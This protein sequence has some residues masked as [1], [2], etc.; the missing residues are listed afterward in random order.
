MVAFSGKRSKP[1]FYYNFKTEQSRETYVQE[2]LQGKLEMSEWKQQQ[3]D[4]RILTE[5]PVK[6][7]DIFYT[8]WGYDQ[9]NVEFYQI[10]DVKGQFAT[11]KQICAQT[12][13]GSQGRDCCE[14]VAMP[15][16]FY[17]RGETLRKKIQTSDNGKTVH[18]RLDSSR[19]AWQ[20]NGKPKY[21]SWYH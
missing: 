13:E 10:I 17:E 3:Q 12:V 2:Y 11:L 4:K 19:S 14:V 6:V 20:W 8:S 1:D 9:T 18:F 5:N 7:G 21:N 16:A 15:N